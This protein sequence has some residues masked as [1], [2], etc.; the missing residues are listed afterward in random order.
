MTKSTSSPSK[1]ATATKKKN[2]KYYRPFLIFL[3]NSC[4]RDTLSTVELFLDYNEMSEH[5]ND[6]IIKT[7]DKNAKDHG[8]ENV[9]DSDDKSNN[10]DSSK[11]L[12]RKDAN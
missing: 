8:E 10:D 4:D 12:Q 2:H 7:A 1:A 5:I 6:Q 11:I 3:S 9:D